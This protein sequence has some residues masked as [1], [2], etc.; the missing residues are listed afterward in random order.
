MQKLIEHRSNEHMGLESAQS[1]PAPGSQQASAD[2]QG[3]EIDAARIK[4]PRKAIKQIQCPK[5]E[6][7]CKSRQTMEK[8]MADHE[9][10]E[11]SGFNCFYCSA[12]FRDKD[13][14]LDHLTTHT[15]FNPG[16]WETFFMTSEEEDQQL[17]AAAK[18][19]AKVTAA[20]AAAI[21][22]EGKLTSEN[23]ADENKQQSETMAPL[24]VPVSSISSTEERIQKILSEVPKHVLDSAEAKSTAEQV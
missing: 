10:L 15:A 11:N 8:H 9:E 2:Q 22:S 14:L 7:V 1:S 3:E 5:C 21:E 6:F 16:E 13:C 12:Q 4:H 19:E 24:P 18:A 17:R 20:A 23:N